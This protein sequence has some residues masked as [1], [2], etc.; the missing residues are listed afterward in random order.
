MSKQE[1]GV[2]S[3]ICETNVLT[4][5]FGNNTYNTYLNLL[6]KIIINKKYLTERAKE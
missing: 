2:G 6:I 5:G 4:N 3:I 1:I